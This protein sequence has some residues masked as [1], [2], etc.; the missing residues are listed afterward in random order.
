MATAPPRPLV[1]APV[2][3]QICPLLP[4]LEVPELKISTPDAPAEPAFE[5]RITT[6][7]LELEMPWPPARLIEPPVEVPS[8]PPAYA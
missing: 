1:A 3:N 6:A 2:P 5:L 7:P 8:P 4:L